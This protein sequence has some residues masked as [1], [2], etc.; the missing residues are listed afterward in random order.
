MTPFVSL[1]TNLFCFLLCLNRQ[2]FNS[3]SLRRKQTQTPAN[4]N[5]P[6]VDLIPA[7]PIELF[8]NLAQANTNRSGAERST[9]ELSRMFD[10]QTIKIIHSKYN[11][12]FSID[13]CLF[14]Y[15]TQTKII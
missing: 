1:S 9:I 10:Y 12:R 7:N 13:F 6:V 4:I 2:V 11:I 15:R 3:L 14:D 5:V 8:D